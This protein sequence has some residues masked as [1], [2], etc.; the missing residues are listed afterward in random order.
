[1][2]EE[3]KYPLATRKVTFATGRKMLFRDPKFSDI[4][5]AGAKASRGGFDPMGFL[6][7]QIRIIAVALLRKNGE[8]V[9]I[10]NRD[11]LFEE[12]LTYAEGQQLLQNPNC[13]GL[14]LET[15]EPEVEML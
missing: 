2:S 6:A 5:Q 11:K 1:M 8:E 7:E 3:K 9:D 12:I 4:R 14:E 15:T 13:L 10:T